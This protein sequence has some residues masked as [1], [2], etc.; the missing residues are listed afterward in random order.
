MRSIVSFLVLLSVKYA[1]K[2]FF[3]FKVEW[4]GGRPDNPWKDLRVLAVL[5]HT[6]LYEPILVGAAENALIWRVARY[7]VLPVAAKTMRR[8]VGLFFRLLANQVVVVTRKKDHTW[9]QVLDAVEGDSTA[10]MVILPEGRMMRSNGLD[11]EGRPMTVRGGIADILR[12]IPSGDMLLVYSG[13]LH[14]IQAPGELLPRLFKTVRL[15]LELVDIAAYR[16]EL[17]TR[18]GDEGFK[19]AVIADLEQ[20]RDTHCPTDPPLHQ[21]RTRQQRDGGRHLGAA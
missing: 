7:G 3:R 4:V 21:L 5:H 2:I 11:S 8:T 9:K 17:M 15:R 14:H 18:A 19:R 6:S 16:E 13:G 20:R 10:L 12:S 1:S